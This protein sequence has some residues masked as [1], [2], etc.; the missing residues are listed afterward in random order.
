MKKID[1]LYIFWEDLLKYKKK[2]M[3]VNQSLNCTFMGTIKVRK[4]NV[5]FK[6]IS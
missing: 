5:Y 1:E 6:T 2:L 3:V 4:F